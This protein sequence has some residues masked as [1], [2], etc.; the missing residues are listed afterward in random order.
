MLRNRLIKKIC[1]ITSVI[2]AIFIINIFPKESTVYH[3]NNK[4]YKGTIYL[5][6][7]N[8]FIAKIDM[9]FES[10]NTIDLINEIISIMTKNTNDSLKIRDGFTPPIPEKTKLINTNVKDNIATL[11]FNEYINDI[12]PSLSEKMIQSIV[13]SI[14]SINSIDKVNILINNKEISKIPNTNIDI[15]NPISKDIKINKI[16]NINDIKNI[17]EVTIFYPAKLNNYNYVIPV[18][19]YSN[20]N[21]EK[22]E[23][24]IDELKSSSTHNTNLIS[25]INNKTQLISYELNPNSLVLNFNE[26]ILDTNDITEEVTY[27]LLKSVQSSYNVNELVIK[28]ND[29]ILYN[30]IL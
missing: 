15:N 17:N 12:Y 9:N 1:I 29:N 10:K 21:K 30:Y 18:T 11:N 5:L 24:I 6:D 28:V 19:Y 23:I 13:Y 7:N 26:F 4:S 14:T 2:L 25:Y 3:D 20:S 16:F 8:N 22:I 27:S